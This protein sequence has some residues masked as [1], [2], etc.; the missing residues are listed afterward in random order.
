MPRPPTGGT[1]IA[2]ALLT[3]ALVVLAGCG[4]PSEETRQNR[5]LGD[6]ALTAVTMKN[7]KELG[8]CKGLLDKRRADGLL[9]EE[10]HRQ[11]AEIIAEAQAGRWAEAE[12]ALY[13][14]RASHP[15][16]K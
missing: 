9:S 16:P 3:A 8:K 6:A 7:G 5:R 1:A 2:R 4:E 11:L 13:K 10:R 12:E 14:F 15:F